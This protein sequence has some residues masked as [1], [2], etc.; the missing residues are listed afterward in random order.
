VDEAFS[1]APALRCPKCKVD[2]PLVTSMANGVVKTEIVGCKC[3]RV[4]EVPVR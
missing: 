4:E 1:P 2:G 3:K